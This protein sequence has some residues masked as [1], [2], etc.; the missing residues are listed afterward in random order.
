[1]DSTAETT[2]K[3]IDATAPTPPQKDRWGFLKTAK[4]KL[5]QKVQQFKA[6]QKLNL[7]RLQMAKENAQKVNVRKKLAQVAFVALSQVDD[8]GTYME[9][10]NRIPKDLNVL[11]PDVFIPES[12]VIHPLL[13]SRMLVQLVNLLTKEM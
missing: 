1:M 2:P 11:R 9:Q 5:T 6:N 13:K 8:A 7:V 3:G 4:A 10:T 12:P